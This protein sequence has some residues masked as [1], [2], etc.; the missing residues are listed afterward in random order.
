MK[1]WYNNSSI[2][3]QLDDGS[4][5][6]DGFILGRL[7]FSDSCREKMSKS[8][9]GKYNRKN[10][11][12]H[13]E[14]DKKKISESLRKHYS[15]VDH[16]SKG[17]SS[18]NKGLK[19][20]QSAWNK[21]MTYEQCHRTSKQNMVDNINK[22]K[23]KNNSFNISKREDEFYELLKNVFDESDI[24][25]QYL[26]ERYPYKC[27]FYIKSEDLFIEYNGTWTHMDRPYDKD[28]D[29]CKNILSKLEEKAKTSNYYKNAIHTWV[30]LDTKKLQYANNYKLKYLVIYKNH[31]TLEE[32]QRL[33]KECSERNIQFLLE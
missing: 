3:I 20:Y 10:N 13:S 8:R 14:E 30:D 12:N 22:T 29:H 4:I 15:K 11:P 9:I 2:E 28:D 19:G 25:R 17:K 33:S 24:Y 27:D 23:M 31:P 18:W 16:P 5:I 1:H 32:V 26:D 7:K 21:N 6:P